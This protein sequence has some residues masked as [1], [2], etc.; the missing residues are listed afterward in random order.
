MPSTGFNGRF[1]WVELWGSD[2]RNPSAGYAHSRGS[3]VKLPFAVSAVAL[4]CAASALNAAQTQPSAAQTIL[5]GAWELNRQASSPTPAG[6]GPDAEARPRRGG[7]GG[8]GPGGGG[9]RGGFGGPGMGGRRR[10]GSGGFGGSSDQL[11]KEEMQRI[12]DVIQE[13]LAAPPRLVIDQ[14][15][16]VVTFTDDEGHVRRFTSNGKPAKHQLTSG[17]V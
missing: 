9:G 11:D 6:L 7:P 13:T 5:S 1:E 14:D 15:G 4:L 2:Q 12:R 10:A 16:S 17:T 3:H 8:G